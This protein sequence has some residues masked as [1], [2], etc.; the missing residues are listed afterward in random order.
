[1]QRG[2]IATPPP[3]QTRAPQR[4][5]A[6]WWQGIRQAQRDRAV[7]WEGF[8]RS[9]LE[10]HRAQK[11]TYATGYE[12]ARMLFEQQVREH[13]N[14]RIEAQEAHMRRYGPS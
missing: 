8:L 5:R 9:V 7:S 13:Q 14:Q 6:G 11:Q 3:L 4:R 10:T 12:R 1:M 2:Y